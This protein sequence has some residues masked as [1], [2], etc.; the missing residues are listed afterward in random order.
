MLR[1]IQDLDVK[2][3]AV[4]GLAAKNLVSGGRLEQFKAALC[5][6]KRQARDRPHRQIEK[7]ADRFPKERL[8]YA[9]QRAI[10]RPRADRRLR[11]FLLD[12]VPKPVQFLDRRREIGIR[13]ERPLALRIE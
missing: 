11:T 3:E 10:E 5:V 8:V 2:P 1:N 13:Q 4:Q 6:M 12:R 7:P 9:D